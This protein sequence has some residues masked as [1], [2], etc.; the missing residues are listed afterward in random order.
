MDENE[1]RKYRKTAV[2][3]RGKKCYDK[4]GAVTAANAFSKRG[5]GYLR[6][7]PCPKGAH[8]HITHVKTAAELRAPLE[9]EDE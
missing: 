1:Q 2:Y 7:Y 3:C 4:K 6:A 8:W 9:G 5:A